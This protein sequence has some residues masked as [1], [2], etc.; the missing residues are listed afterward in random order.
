MLSLKN[1][2]TL[3]SL[4]KNEDCLRYEALG[5]WDVF[6]EDA[7]GYKLYRSWNS[8]NPSAGREEY[9]KYPVDWVAYFERLEI[10]L[11]TPLGK[12]FVLISFVGQLLP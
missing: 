10:F 7:N 5:A 8:Y 1:F 3:H 6:M 12:F 9:Q 4:D 11:K 2:L